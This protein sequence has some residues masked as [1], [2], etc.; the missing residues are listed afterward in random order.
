MYYPSR[1]FFVTEQ[2]IATMHFLGRRV[3]IFLLVF[4][5]SLSF[6]RKVGYQTACFG[7]RARRV[8]IQE[9]RPEEVLKMFRKLKEEG[10]MV[11]TGK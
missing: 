2:K 8:Y 10:K 3:H 1:Q 4:F 7:N 11:G 5:S 9:K 6:T